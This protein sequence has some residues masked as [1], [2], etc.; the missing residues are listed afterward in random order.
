MYKELEMRVAHKGISKKKLADDLHMNYRTL[1]AKMEGKSKFTL[2]EAVLIR[3][4]LDED[5]SVEE[6]FKEIR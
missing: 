1:L 2:D 5:T 6:L 3:A 4:Y